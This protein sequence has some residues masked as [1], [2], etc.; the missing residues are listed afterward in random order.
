MKRRKPAINGSR[1]PWPYEDYIPKYRG[2]P[3]I[4]SGW[5]GKQGEGEGIGD[6]LVHIAGELTL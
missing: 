6:W 3:G 5:V 2:M 1:G 4:G